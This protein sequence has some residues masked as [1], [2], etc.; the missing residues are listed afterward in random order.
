MLERKGVMWNGWF[1]ILIK[2]AY[3]TRTLA[4]NLYKAN[5]ILV[6]KNVV[7]RGSGEPNPVIP[8][9]QTFTIV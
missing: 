7:T 8:Q 9:E 2:P 6:D 5:G 4:L 1:S 3:F